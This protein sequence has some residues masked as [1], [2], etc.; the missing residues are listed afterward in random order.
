MTNK[1]GQKYQC[2]VPKPKDYKEEE[3]KLKTSK[4][5]GES[6]E[7]EALEMTDLEKAKKLLEPMASQPCLLRYTQGHNIPDA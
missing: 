7:Q 2:K 4:A 6:T 1:H 5:D 3:K